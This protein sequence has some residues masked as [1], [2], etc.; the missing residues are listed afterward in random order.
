MAGAGGLVER[1]RE[2]GLLAGYLA[3]V[4]AGT[5][6]VVVI[7]GPAG[8]GKSRLLAE[9][10]ATA[11]QAGLQVLHARASELERDF[12]FGVV[13]QLF[14]GVRLDPDLD[15]AAFEG[16]AAPARAVLGAFGDDDATPGDASF[17][18]L[19]GLFWMALNLANR[20]PLLLAIDDLH[21]ADR[22]SLRFLTYLV[23]RLDG[24]PILIAAT[25]RSGEPGVDPRLIGELVHDPAEASLR[26][27]PLSVE[28]VA[29][30]LAEQLDAP[31]DPAF[32]D[33]CHRA[34]GGNPLLLRQLARALE[35]DRVPPDAAHA[36]T[37]R[38]I[39][40]RAVSRTLLLR[41]ARLDA[42]AIRVAQAVAVLG[43]SAELGAVARLTGL[44]ERAVAEAT[45]AL[46]AVEILRPD[47]PLGFVHPLVRDAVYHELPATER[48]LEHARAATVLDELGAPD[49]AVAAQLL[50]APARGDQG[51]VQRLQRAAAGANRRGAAESA[52]AY[53][54]RALREPVAAEARPRLLLQLGLAEALTWG[55]GAREHLTEAWDGLTDPLERALAAGVLARAVLF[56]ASAPAEAREVA[57][58]GARELPDAMADERRQLQAMADVT[59]IFG[60]DRAELTDVRRWRDVP[61]DEVR[62][63]GARML[64]GLAAWDATQQGEPADAC[65]ALALRSLAEGEL[66]SRDNGLLS[67]A[68]LAS[69]TFCDRDEVLAA[70]D[71]ALA[72]AHRHGSLFSMM[73]A[74]LWLGA[75]LLQRG[76]LVEAE[77]ELRQAREDF[78]AWGNVGGLR[79]CSAFLS[80]VLLARGD[81]TG[82]RE[83]IEIARDGG[84]DSD[85][86]VFWLHASLELTLAEGRHEDVV[87]RARE[88]ID[89]F[90]AVPNPALTPWRSQLGE[91][92][93]RLGRG[94]EALPLVEEELALV[95][96]FGAP[97]A[98]ARTLR[99]LGLLQGD[100]GV[101]TLQEAVDVA[102]ASPARYELARSLAALGEVL[103]R[104]RRPG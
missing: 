92:L 87:A 51:V 52:V 98:L 82:A 72:D 15:A 77:T 47:T 59:L 70:W 18:A 29:A 38:Q 34:T 69:L 68:A 30:V 48:E 89:R 14:E 63:P 75:A 19:H 11:E 42:S 28:A 58:R 43:D 83:A 65:A 62:G 33:A 93:G 97:S 31:V 53:L 104:A 60:L 5:G 6:R 36:E 76:A 55:P 27:A 64:V 73:A 8:I 50:L 17:A 37:V 78:A 3:D 94:D 24:V 25:L 67:I 9:A 4:R 13:R 74:H 10:R 100:D 54:T 71:E 86:S 84:D 91:A 90:R 16:A 40:P 99:V 96:R 41:L 32:A 57:L 26:P 66:L 80:R 56:T 85:G 23:R 101:A 61:A 22:P 21:W 44:D 88:A 46:A 45:R 2:L 49:D 79:Y 12:A 103:R 95:R 7:E 1:E 35:G 39:G 102:T 81:L 20:R